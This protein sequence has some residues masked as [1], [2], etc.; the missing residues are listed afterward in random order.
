MLCLAHPVTLILKRAS[1]YSDTLQCV[2]FASV[3]IGA[4]MPIPM[5]TSSDFLRAAIVS[6]AM[7]VG[8]VTFAFIIILHY[9]DTPKDKTCTLYL[10]ICSLPTMYRP[11]L[12]PSHPT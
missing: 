4:A 3:L 10:A 7:A 1:G 9:I 6:A 11:I 12:I 8:G 2:R 5:L